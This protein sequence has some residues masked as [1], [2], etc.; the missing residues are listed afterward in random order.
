MSDTNNNNKQ[1]NNFPTPEDNIVQTQH[2]LTIGGVSLDYTATTG[3][4]VL[5]EESE[6]DDKAEGEKAKAS[7]FFVAYTKNDVVD[8]GKRPI[9]F[10]F[11]GGPG[12]SSVWLPIC[13]QIQEPALEPDI[14]FGNKSCSIK[15]CTT[16]W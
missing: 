4:I 7:I 14:T 16:P 1:V 8:A 6:K 12:S 10:A 2:T 11:N 3:T 5:R 9:T 15:V 13:A